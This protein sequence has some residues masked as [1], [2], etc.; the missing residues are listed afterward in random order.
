LRFR[1]TAARSF[2]SRRKKEVMAVMVA[3]EV[4]M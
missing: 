4:S 3:A 1:V 2:V